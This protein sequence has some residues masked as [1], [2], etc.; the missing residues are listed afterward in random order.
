LAAESYL[1]LYEGVEGSQ[2][3]SLHCPF[4]AL[5]Q[6]LKTQYPHVNPQSNTPPVLSTALKMADDSSCQ[7]LAMLAS[8]PE[9]LQKLSETLLPTLTKQIR[10][11]Q[12]E[13][14]NG[15][16]GRNGNVGNH[17]SSALHDPN[18]SRGNEANISGN[19]PTPSGANWQDNEAVN[20]R[21]DPHGN[22]L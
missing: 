9:M 20:G 1:R 4:N 19:N 16:A 11:S 6:L 10:E 5:H 8:C 14:A 2:H 15:S 18:V 22:G 17:V 21:N 3:V 13:A 7:L 12:S